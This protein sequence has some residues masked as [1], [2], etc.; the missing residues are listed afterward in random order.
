MKI[1]ITSLG[2]AGR[3]LVE[4]LSLMAELGAECTE[5]NGRPGVHPDITW[6]PGDVKKVKK[7]LDETGI[8]ATSLGGYNDFAQLNAEGLEAQIVQFVGYCQRAADLEI[9]VVRA[10]GAD[11][12]AGHTLVDFREQ[13]F[14]GF[15]EVVKRTEGLGVV[16]AIENHG[17]LTNDGDFMQEIIQHVGSPRLGVTLDTGNFAWAGYSDETVERFF[18]DLLPSIFSL[19][20]KDGIWGD[21]GG[22]EFVP[23]GRGEMRLPKLLSALAGRGF[24]GGIV[25]E[26]EGKGDYVEG[27]RESVA[28]LRGVRD[29]VLAG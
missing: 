24:E 6:A 17:R 1:G 16:I 18:D 29:G 3:S 5:L 10:F 20:I 11:A 28:Y 23:A 14:R 25:S 19:H 2:M 12:K 4:A 7:L 9:P 27:T 21:G 13:I 22:F 8:V 26:F 15:E